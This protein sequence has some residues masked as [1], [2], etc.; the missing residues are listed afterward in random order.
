[1]SN[2]Y[3][4]QDDYWLAQSATPTEQFP[5]A[6]PPGMAPHAAGSG[7]A[8]TPDHRPTSAPAGWYPD[9]RDRTIQ[10]WW[11]GQGWTAH[12][13][14]LVAQP[15]AGYYPPYSP[16]PIYINNMASSSSPVMVN[17]Q[18]PV[19]HLLHFILTILTFGLWLPI[20][21]IVTVARR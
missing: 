14:P 8:H 7:F 13:A 10:R 3:G 15:A 11:D 2:N 18:R 17:Y 9:A 4:H 12:I 1:M 16:P 19:N 20:W 5:H 21:I 6:Q